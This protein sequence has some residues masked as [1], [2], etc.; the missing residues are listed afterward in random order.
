MKNILAKLHAIMVDT[1]K[2][3]KNGKNGFHGYKYLSDEDLI[4]HFHNK[5]SEHGV[6]FDVESADITQL[7]K[8]EKD[9]NK[10]KGYLVTVRVK[11]RFIDIETGEFLGGSMDG[12]GHDNPG[13]KAAYKAHTGAIKYVFIKRF[14]VPTKDDPENDGHVEE[15]SE[16]DQEPTYHQEGGQTCPKCGKKH[17]GKF[18]KCLDCWKA[19]KK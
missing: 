5:L 19:E 1:V 14:L 3:E 12:M 11:Y 2:I 9:E 10:E 17:N 13:D 6:I 4:L 16:R 18:P 8:M 7:V 15:E